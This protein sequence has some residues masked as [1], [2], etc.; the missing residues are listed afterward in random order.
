MIIYPSVLIK[1]D[2]LV[3]IQASYE[4]NVDKGVLWYDF[5]IEYEEYLVLENSD[6]FLV[7]LLL[8]AMKTGEDLFI[9]SKISSKLFYNITTYLIPALLLSNNN[10]KAIKIIITNDFISLDISITYVIVLL[11]SSFCC[12]VI[13]DSNNTL[14]IKYVYHFV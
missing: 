6:A 3:R 1:H 13:I 9:K 12:F 2:D 7:A 14:C 11:Q 5:P 4:T 10:Y 8:Q